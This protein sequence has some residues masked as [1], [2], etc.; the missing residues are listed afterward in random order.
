MDLHHF[1]LQGEL[2]IPGLALRVLTAEVHGLT[3]PATDR[4]FTSGRG[5]PRAFWRE[6]DDPRRRDNVC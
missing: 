1:V 5:N 3:A 2:G 6:T 4:R